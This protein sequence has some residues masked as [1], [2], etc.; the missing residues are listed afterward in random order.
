MGTPVDRWDFERHGPPGLEAI[1]LRHL[2]AEEY[3]VSPSHYPAGTT[4]SGAARA[5]RWYVLAGLCA[6]EVGSS[7]WELRAGD[8]ADIPAGE[9]HFRASDSDGAELVRVWELP[10]EARDGGPDPAP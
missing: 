3:R 4:F 2:P 7:S 10:P 5:G 1:R 8:I 9:Y 6:I